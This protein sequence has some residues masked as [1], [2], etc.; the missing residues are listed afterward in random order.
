MTKASSFRGIGILIFVFVIPAGN[1]LLLS[2]ARPAQG[3]GLALN[4]TNTPP[5]SATADPMPPAMVIG[6]VGGFIRHDDP[7]HSEVQLAA[8]LR[9]EYPSGV[10]VETFESYHGENA[11]KRILSVLDTNH[12][13]QLTPSEKQNARIILYGHSWGASEAIT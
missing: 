13:G 3:S 10:D 4:G 1:I 8:R 12:D 7:V 6:F 11:K 9:Q 5:S 2:R